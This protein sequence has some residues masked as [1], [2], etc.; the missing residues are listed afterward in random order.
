[1][2]EHLSNSGRRSLLVSC[3]PL[4]DSLCNH[5]VARVKQ[6]FAG[7]PIEVEHLDLYDSD[8][9]A[10]LS[11]AERSGYW[12]FRPPR[13]LDAGPCAWG[14]RLFAS[15]LF[16]STVIPMGDYTSQN[17]VVRYVGG[18]RKGVAPWE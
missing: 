7:H 18:F 11:A 3:H 10:P 2:T 4:A 9:A 13:Q 8:F 6:R 5:P 14:R 15:F 12:P 16:A 1:M 17:F